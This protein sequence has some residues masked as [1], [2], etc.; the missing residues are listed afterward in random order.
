LIVPGTAGLGDADSL[1]AEDHDLARRIQSSLV[2]AFDAARDRFIGELVRHVDQG[3]HEEAA[4]LF[5]THDDAWFAVQARNRALLDAALQVDPDRLSIEARTTFVR[6][7]A[8]LGCDMRRFSEVE[9][10]IRAAL[11]NECSGVWRA[12]WGLALARSALQK[13]HRELALH[14]AQELAEEAPDELPATERAAIFGLVSEILPEADPDGAHYAVRAKDLFLMGADRRGAAQYQTRRAVALQRHDPRQALALLDE[15][16]H[17][18]TDDDLQSRYTRARLYHLAAVFSAEAHNWHQARDAAQESVNELRRLIGAED[19]LVATL[20]ILSEAETKLGNADSARRCS[21]EATELASRLGDPRLMARQLLARSL[22]QEGEAAAEALS[23]VPE[24]DPEH[25]FWKALILA[26][27]A[28]TL[29]D[30]LRACEDARTLIEKHD[31]HGHDAYL[32]HWTMGQLLA[33]HGR[34]HRAIEHL[35]QATQLSPWTFE[36]RDLLVKLLWDEDRWSEAVQVLRS[37]ISLLG[38]LPGLTFALGKSLLEAGQVQEASTVL[39]AVRRSGSP[40]ADAAHTLLDRAIMAGGVPELPSTPTASPQPTLDEVR[41]TLADFA[42]NIANNQRM[43]FWRSRERRHIWREQ[44]E[45]HGKQL[46]MAALPMSLGDG[47]EI[48][49]EVKAGAGRIDLYVRL[50][51]L[52]VVVELKMCGGG[53]YTTA[54]ALG[55]LDQLAHYMVAKGTG[56]G[57]LVVFDGR[58]RD[59]GVGLEP[60][61]VQGDRTIYVVP[62]DV[63]PEVAARDPE[64]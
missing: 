4:R 64:T 57:F 20:E 53:N 26:M 11:S 24:R 46:L 22:R 40:H 58:T 38:R 55:G 45:D 30:G 41:R 34:N 61:S 16:Q 29:E 7:R 19:M 23:K 50:G 25:A 49:E 14:M 43:S 1:A 8:A 62:V 33:R 17:W 32:V 47:V 28:T 21:E 31:P 18:L 52:R 54:Y 15:A 6:S 59:F 27:K 9:H 39:A 44:P 56:V 37:Q 10:D 35:K 48:L 13:G 63:R 5:E 36:A 42:A 51:A 12:R 3:Q 60:I 2:H